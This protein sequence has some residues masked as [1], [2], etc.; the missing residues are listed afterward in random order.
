MCF[1]NLG[2]Y[3]SSNTTHLQEIAVD[4]QIPSYHIDS[5]ERIGANG[6]EHKP[7]LN[8][9]KNLQTFATAKPIG[10]MTMRCSWR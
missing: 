3:N 9:S 10:S 4:R 5:A 1:A 8:N 6:I 7:L 2:G